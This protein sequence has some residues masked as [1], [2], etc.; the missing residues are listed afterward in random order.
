MTPRAAAVA[1]AASTA[2]PPAFQHISGRS[3]SRTGRPTTR[4]HRGRP[5]S[6]PSAEPWAR[7]RR[8]VRPARW[9]RR[10]SVPRQEAWNVG[11]WPVLR[12]R[13]FGSSQDWL[14]WRKRPAAAE[15]VHHDF[16]GGSFVARSHLVADLD[17]GGRHRPGLPTRAGPRSRPFPVHAGVLATKW[18]ATARGGVGQGH[19]ASTC[20]A[21]ASLSSSTCTPSVHRAQEEA[22]ARI[23]TAT[24]L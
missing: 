2:L 13:L 7:R 4:R 20:R 6:G 19:P 14:P 10:S 12:L 8:V 24:K 22:P 21:T 23:Y 1:T 17:R 3:R 15:N 11:T 18:G 9:P 16:D 5:Q